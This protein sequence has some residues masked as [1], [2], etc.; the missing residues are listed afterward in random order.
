MA[1]L[2]PTYIPAPN[3]D[4]PA[5]S[6]LV[7]LG[8][9]IKDPTDPESKIPGSRDDP[10]PPR[11]IYEGSKLDWTTTTE[12]L[13]SGSIGLWAKCLQWVGGGLSL[14]QL[15]ASLKS[16]RFDVLETAYFRPDDDYYAQV[17]SDTGVQAYLEVHRWRKPVYLVTGIKIARVAT[18]TTQNSTD[19]E[20]KM[21]LKADAT[22]VGVPLDAG[23]ELST[24]STK[25]KGTSFGGSTDYIFA[26]RLTRM[27]PRKRGET[28]EEKAFVKGAVY[29]MGADENKTKLRD[30]FIIEEEN[31]LG[32]EDSLE[33]VEDE[34][35]DCN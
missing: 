32:F 35:R 21:E 19:R 31:Q 27:K 28:S 33:Y 24:E 34:L 9:L 17:L 12:Q 4:I 2:M 15:K 13:R 14:Q 30:R 5:D 16:H 20:M 3:W 25:A 10:V 8:R 23:P 7:V 18:V 26:Y 1:N 11:R 29:D 22:M 6:D